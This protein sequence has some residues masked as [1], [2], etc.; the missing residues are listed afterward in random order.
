MY[1]ARWAKPALRTYDRLNGDAQRRVLSAIR[2]LCAD[3]FDAANVK[4]LSGPLK[5]KYRRRVGDLRIIYS[6]DSTAKELYVLTIDWR[7]NVY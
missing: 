6:L 2:D 7:G 3:P 5:G 1:R 4:A